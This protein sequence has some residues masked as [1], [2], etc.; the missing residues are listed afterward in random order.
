M[1]AS[2]Q[3]VDST[4]TYGCCVCARALAGFHL[5]AHTR[6]DLAAEY[7]TNAEPKRAVPAPWKCEY[8]YYGCADMSAD[9][10][11]SDATIPYPPMCE[12]GGCNDTEAINYNSSATYNDGSC[13]YHLNGCTVSGCHVCAV[14]AV[15]GLWGELWTYARAQ[16]SAHWVGHTEKPERTKQHGAVQRRHSADLS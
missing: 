16:G 5:F 6:T 14:C 13:T 2:S 1:G 4:L 8:A 9:N 15:C 3:P 10:Y 7:S 11:V 12:Y